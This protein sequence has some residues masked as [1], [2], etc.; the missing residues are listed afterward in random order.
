MCWLPTGTITS[1]SSEIFLSKCKIIT[2][3]IINK[4]LKYC[5]NK[6]LQMYWVYNGLILIASHSHPTSNNLHRWYRNAQQHQSHLP[7]ENTAQCSSKRNTADY[8][9]TFFFAF[10][11]PVGTH[12]SWVAWES[13]LV[14]SRMGFEPTTFRMVNLTRSRTHYTR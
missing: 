8:Q 1:Y 5:L 11:V 3:Y 10:N 9:N 14:M 6:C 12:H 4:L 13:F 7:G 2:H